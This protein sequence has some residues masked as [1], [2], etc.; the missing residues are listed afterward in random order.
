MD[1]LQL[2]I[3]VNV[4]LEISSGIFAC[5]HIIEMHTIQEKNHKIIKEPRNGKSKANNKLTKLSSKVYRI[6]F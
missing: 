6:F 2:L 1:S 4:P 5:D 3:I